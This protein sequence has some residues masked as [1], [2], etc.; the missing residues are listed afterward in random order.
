MTQLNV[1]SNQNGS[2]TTDLL[3]KILEA[4][5]LENRGDLVGA[6]AIYQEVLKLS[7]DGTYGPIAA[8]ALE[9]LSSRVEIPPEL[10]KDVTTSTKKGVAK[11]AKEQKNSNWLLNLPVGAK[12]LTA[13]LLSEA[14]SLSLAWIGVSLVERSLQEQLFDQALSEVSVMEINYNIKVNQMGFGFRGQSDNPAIIAAAIAHAQGKPIPPDLALTVKKVMQNEVKARVIEYATLVGI[15]RRIIVG[16]NSDARI[17]EVYDPSNLVSDVLKNPNQIKASAIVPA[18]DLQK[19]TPPLPPGFTVQDAL[20]RYT[21]TPVRDAN[22]NVVGVLISGDIVNKKQPIV[23]NTL[24]ALG[25][26]SSEPNKRIQGGYSAV[27]MQKPSGEFSL[28]TSS[29]QTDRE[30]LPDV[31]L[32]TGAETS[33]LLQLAAKANGQP[34]T[35]RLVVNG[36]NYTVAARALPGQIIETP[37]GAVPRFTGQ[38]ASILVRG[39]PEITKNAL[40]SNTQNTLLISFGVVIAINFTL[41]FVLS[42]LVVRPIRALT[43]KAKA[44]ASGDRSARAKVFAEDEIGELTRSFNTM[45]DSIVASESALADQSRLKTQEA[46]TQR[47]EKEL[48]QKEVINLLLE[49]EGAQKGDLTVEARI[50]EGEVGSIADAFNATIRKLRQLVEQV[51]L[52]AVQANELAKNSEGN[53]R[54]FSASALSQS[55]GIARALGAVEKNSIAIQQVSQSAQDAAEIAR[56]ALIA[57]KEGD[58]KMDQAVTSIQNIR[59]TVAATSKKVKQLAESSQEISQIVSIITGI[60]EKTNLLAFNASIEA[61]R[62]GENGQGFRVVADEVRRLADRVT[63]ATREIQLLVNTIQQ[64]TVEALQTMEIGTAEVVSGTQLVEQ[65]KETLKGLA[66]ISQNID[67]YLQT[68]SSSTVSQTESTKEVNQIMEDVNTIAQKSASETQSVVLSLQSLVGVVDDLQASVSQF[69]I[70]K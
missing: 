33:T 56:H 51:K 18:A 55:S 17:G 47:L 26:P 13:L 43:P 10:T 65:T 62:A 37:D 15:D 38:P 12:Q 27:Y 8:K 44:F 34:V 9:K 19:E 24:N 7:P 50:S 61:A 45:A 6:V 63:E 28:A 41:A 58:S 14:L 23:K 54:Q 1:T 70:E 48:L 35:G 31:S 21:A 5:D 57:A 29:L 3:P 46:A 69:R 36:L 64:E 40:V 11:E 68:I 39:T 2:S 52:V 49:I 25:K 66:A 59:S 53:V 67:Q 20:I 42:L 32:P 22:R 60:S 4:S 30:F 16:A